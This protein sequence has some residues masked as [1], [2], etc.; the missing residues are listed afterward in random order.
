MCF[1]KMNALRGKRNIRFN[2]EETAL[3][4]YTSRAVFIYVNLIDGYFLFKYHF[5]S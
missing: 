4:V 1:T 3:E 5:L 2:I